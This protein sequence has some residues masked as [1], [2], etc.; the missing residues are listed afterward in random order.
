MSQP[1][2]LAVTV[3]AGAVILAAELDADPS[4]PPFVVHPNVR[5]LSGGDLATVERYVAAIY[6]AKNA[7]TRVPYPTS[8]HF[9]DLA[10]ASTLLAATQALTADLADA[11]QSKK[12]ANPG[13]VFG[14]IVQL[15]NGTEAHALLKVDLEEDPRTYLDLDSP[16]G[17]KLEDVADI[18]PTPKPNVAKYVVAPRPLA[19]GPAGLL[20]VT[21][22]DQD[23]AAYFL[24][25]LGVRVGRTQ[26]TLAMIGR[27][28]VKAGVPVLEA[29]QRLRAVEVGTATEEAVEALF[30]EISER[31]RDRIVSADS[32]RPRTDIGADDTYKVVA[33]SP[34]GAR[35]EVYDKRAEIELSDDRHRITV[36]LPS[37]SP[38]FEMDIKDGPKSRASTAA[39]SDQTPHPSAQIAEGDSG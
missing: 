4:D 20:D 12:S 11:M 27:E 7:P 14:A 33:A 16:G 25:A 9:K 15:D 17:W 10:S 23:P 29:D 6:S 2:F 34:A 24:E 32:L 13:L 28:A 30:P 3:A 35:V 18:L 37:D 26:G 1:G 38:P 31:T 21:N 5:S 19:E 22:R 8:T 36:T 39:G